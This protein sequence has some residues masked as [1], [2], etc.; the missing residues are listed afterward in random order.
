MVLDK[1]INKLSSYFSWLYYRRWEVWELKIAVITIALILF[2]L[3][4]WLASWRRRKTR[5]RIALANQEQEESSVIGVKSGWRMK[6]IAI[7]A[8]IIIGLI[9]LSIFCYR[10]PKPTEG[11][12]LRSHQTGKLIGPVSLP[13]GHP[14]PVLDEQ[15][16]IAADPTKSELDLRNLLLRNHVTATL[17]DIPLTEALDHILA[18]YFG[19][20]SPP[21]RIETEGK[22]KP[23]RVSIDVRD[24]HLY[25]LLF[26]CASQVNLRIILKGGT[27]VFS[28]KRSESEEIAE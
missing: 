25:D 5:A 9:D 11:F 12:Y 24:M 13:E 2:V 8:L 16:Y 15:T 22:S 7:L 4:L 26:D 14:M 1:L 27:I 3:I 20:K 6:K 21:V 28:H 18:A 19:S 10:R 23:L 17:T